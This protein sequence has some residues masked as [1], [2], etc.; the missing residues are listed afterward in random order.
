MYAKCGALTKAQEVLYELPVQNVVCWSALI[1]GYAQYGSGEEALCCFQQMQRERLSPNAITFACALKACGIVQD[2]NA[3][4]RIRDEI[5]SQGLLKGDVVLGSALVEM[6]AKCGVLVKA[7][8][9]LDELLVWN[10]VCWSALISGYAQ[11]SCGK[12]ALSCFRQMRSEGLLADEVSW[13]ALIGGFA[14]QGLAKEALDCFRWMQQE[15]TPPTAVIFVS[16]LNACSHSGLVDEGQTLL[17]NMRDKYGIV[18][19]NE[20]YTCMV[21]LFGRARQFDKA[22]G[23]IKLMPS[24]NY[25]PV[26]SAVLGACQKW[27]DVELGRLAFECAVEY[28]CDSAAYVL[29]RNIYAAADMQEAQN[30][31]SMRIRNGARS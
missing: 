17:D 4:E 15:G 8:T 29:M 16:V 2:V 24:T 30:V 23:V 12:E 10:V 25:L 13:N 27:G 28:K 5:V 9:V 21:D 11:H 7:Q 18:P 1:S 20:H 22:M 26:W 31:K 19:D 6:Y 14:Q 3:G